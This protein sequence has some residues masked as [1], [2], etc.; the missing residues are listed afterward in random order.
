MGASTPRAWPI[1][2]EHDTVLRLE[3]AERPPGR[4][5]VGSILRGTG[6]SSPS[7][8]GRRLS[9][10][11]L[12]TPIFWALHYYLL[13]GDGET[14]ESELCEEL[15]GNSSQEI[16][17]YYLERFTSQ[18]QPNPW[19]YFS[20]P[21]GDSR[22]IEVEYADAV[23]YQTRY[24]IGDNTGVITLGYDSGHFS[25]PSFRWP[26]VLDIAN[27]CDTPSR[28]HQVILLLFPGIY[29]GAADEAEATSEL[30]KGFTEL[31]LFNV[32][33]RSN[34]AKNAVR[35]RRIE[36]AWV[37]DER[38]GWISTGDYAQRNPNSLLSQLTEGDFLR[39]KAF[40]V[41]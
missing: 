12:D 27:A 24:K 20:I 3:L 22:A 17:D 34:L 37:C 36:S 18:R 21:I 9:N 39:I 29:V 4:I 2:P 32:E 6:L 30:V 14:D 33:G 13:A 25:L 31:G 8:N 23:D 28:R 19:P 38:L 7:P 41:P 5:A 35:Y 10:D 26:E 15:F 40:F 1:L 16:N 11:W